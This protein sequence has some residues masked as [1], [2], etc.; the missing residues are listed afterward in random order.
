VTTKDDM[1]PK[2][3]SRIIDA[4]R[5]GI[6]PSGYVQQ[7]TVGR[8][9]EI[10]QLSAKLQNN[11]PGPLLLKANYGSGKTHLL[12]FVRE[13]ALA[14]NY[15][16]SSVTL[17]AKSAVRFN[18]MDQMLGAIW[19]GL[20]LPRVSGKKGV[21]PF[22]DM[23]HHHIEH[24]KTNSS[25]HEFWSQ[26][27]NKWRWDYSNALES[28]AMFIAIRA[29]ATEKPETHDLIEDWFFQPWTYYAQRK[30]LYTE[31]VKKHRSHFRDPRPE[32]K[33]YSTS[34]G[35]FNF[36]LQDYSQ[37]WEALRDIQVLCEKA[38]LSGFVILF[39]EFEDVIYNLNRINHQEAAFWNLFQF[40]FGSQFQGLSFF[41][42]TPDFV[43]KCKQR[44][45]EKNRWDY[46]YS[47]FDELPTFEMSPLEREQIQ[48]LLVKICETHS[49]AYDWQPSI[50]PDELTRAAFRSAAPN[51]QDRTRVAIRE[52]IKYLDRA[53]EDGD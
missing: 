4:L 9:A 13:V 28:P 21:R 17:D 23:V 36:Q 26:L 11:K 5:S 39:D 41:A 29:W 32:W 12:R 53:L 2:E 6:P 35:F 22:F 33:F 1:S 30:H 24:A 52:T 48:E 46:D 14:E 51:V 50:S 27:T 31:L 49:L 25:G 42:V 3:A 16:V 38:G 47:L 40:Y 18:R 45:L 44:L 34:E 19:R 8:Q 37:S 15:A 43:N 20:E 7:F 10:T